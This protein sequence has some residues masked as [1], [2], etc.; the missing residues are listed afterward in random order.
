MQLVHWARGY[1]SSLIIEWG[2]IPTGHIIAAICW[3]SE[4][5]G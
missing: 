2:W 1:E 4:S 3:K 5:L